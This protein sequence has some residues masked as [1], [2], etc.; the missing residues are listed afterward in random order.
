MI[1]IMISLVLGDKPRPY[2]FRPEYAP[3]YMY[4]LNQY[5]LFSFLPLEDELSLKVQL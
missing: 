1:S 2:P 4:T 3:H 5:L